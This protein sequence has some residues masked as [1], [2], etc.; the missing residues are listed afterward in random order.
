MSASLLNELKLQ[1]AQ[2]LIK[3]QEWLERKYTTAKQRLKRGQ[4]ADRMLAEL[5]TRV[6]R[7]LESVAARHWPDKINYPNLPVSL[8]KDE[9]KQAI[10][11]H[12][13][14][15]VA[16]ETG[17]GKTTQLPKMCLELGFGQR[18]LVGHTQPRRLAARTVAN[19]I[20]EELDGALGQRVGYQVRF[21]EEVSASTQVKLMTDG[22]LLA[23]IQ[24]DPMLLDYEVIIIDEAHERSLNIDFLL[25]YLKQLLPKRP[26]LKLLITSATID[27]ERFSKH[28]DGAPIIEVSGRTYPVEVIYQADIDDGES[29]SMPGQILGAIE[30]L[31]ATEPA[32]HGPGDVLVFLSGEREIREAATYLRKAQTFSA[33]LKHTEILPLYARLSLAEQNRVFN[34]QTRRGRRIVLATNV[35]ET[36]L[37]VPGIRYVV[38]TGTARISRYS[39][40]SKVQ[41]L[42][43]EAVSKASANQ[44]AGRCGRV[45]AG[46]CI[47]LYSEADFTARPDYTDAEIR[48]TNL[49]AVILQ[50]LALKLGDIADFPFI[51]PPDS[52]FINDGFKLLQE[53]GAVDD[54]R[55]MTRVGHLLSRLPV[56]PRLG[57]MIV[58]AAQNNCLREVLIIVSALSVQD[59]R[60]RPA[61]K[62]Q[63]SDEK[64][65]SYA[66]EESD[67]LTF[68][69]LWQ[70]Y[71]EQRQAL[72]Q[73]QLRQFCQKNYLSFMRMREWRDVHRQL[74][75]FCRDLSKREASFIERPDPADYAPVHRSL[76]AGL[77]SHMGFKQEKKEY[78]G[79]RNRRFQL[80]PGSGLYK[81]P[82]KWLMAAELV[83][84]SQ[85]YARCVAKIEP[86]WAESLAG[87]LVKRNYS[88]PHW[89]QKRAQVVATE[90]VLLYGLV[91][92]P[93]RS[94]NYGVID[95]EVSHQ[96]MIR[97]ALV[98]G[99]FKARLPFIEQNRQLLE[100]VALLEEK[101]RRRDLLVDE[102]QLFDFYQQRL[103]QLDGRAV[104]NGAGFEKWFRQL[105]SEQQQMLELTAED[106]L[107]RSTGHVSAAAYPDYF[108]WESH[109]LRL[110]YHFAPG[111]DDD[112][113]SLQVPL[114]LLQQLPLQQ[115]EWLVPGMLE[116]KCIALLKGLPKQRRKHFV[117]VPDYAR[118]FVEAMVF[119]EGDLYERLAHHLLR[120]SGVRLEPD[121]LRQ[122]ALPDHFYMNL[123]LLDA[124][125]ELVAQSRSWQTLQQQ[126]ADEVEKQLNVQPRQQ[127]GKEAITG[128]DFGEI[129]SSV[130]I[131]Q[132][133]GVEVE[134][135]PALEERGDTVALCLKATMEEAEQVSRMGVVQLAL[136]ALTEPVKYLRQKKQQNR[137]ATLVLQ[138]GGTWSVTELQQQ[139]ILQTCRQLLG[140]DDDLPRTQQVFEARLEVC[141]ANLVE[142]YE[143]L[144][145]W[146]QQC[147][148]TTHSINKQLKG[149]LQLNEVTVLN[150]IKQQL[151]A[152]FSAKFIANTEW[153][154]LEHYPRYLLAIEA[155]LEKFRRNLRAQT[156]QSEQIQQLF[157]QYEARQAERNQQGLCDRQ[158][159]TYRWMLEEYRVSLFAQQ[160]GTQYPVSEKRLRQQWQLVS[161]G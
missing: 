155:R 41:R 115:M 45:A 8:K 96:L 148:A 141:R 52:R 7:S 56:D 78:L 125:G 108:Q 50:M 109:R 86:Q 133:A 93:K 101:S 146:L 19:R 128:W 72:S 94:V 160:L 143:V 107:Q 58:E 37:T 9:I 91:I 77:L 6:S 90:Q 95:P 29:D 18:G 48:R 43:I 76:L 111:A 68:V 110:A 139:M 84:T 5:Q 161:A 23:A 104:V 106:V 98:E 27:L 64:H 154:Y 153:Q 120:M 63:A 112:G 85:L 135:Y 142:R 15:V 60:E 124:K 117:P 38:D 127:W 87:H 103:Y 113:V 62:Q 1:F 69:N 97:G 21:H 129:K 82:P 151:A 159:I 24:S 36:S 11:A 32:G 46:I 61:D 14:V 79:A 147:A 88:E 53:L 99:Q 121:E 118:A 144:L 114:P 59:P 13:V 119:A 35:A 105:T 40:R 10:A 134:A 2:C 75:L 116:D 132:Y 47:R 89:Q 138:L 67:F 33:A 39:Y 16:G 126:F 3:D 137:L 81:K 30:T 83:E 20:A 156:L 22:L 74:H 71:E 102:E 25:G 150:D 152:L 123:R 4:P 42:P 51:D 158:L 92:I 57:R 44:R 131:S 122:V 26:D 49:A 55:R 157:Q 80:F 34:S 65:R 145:A 140:V 28:F 17:S 136:L 70:L 31:V 73:S 66:H 130:R 149:K 12:Q 100:S 54:R